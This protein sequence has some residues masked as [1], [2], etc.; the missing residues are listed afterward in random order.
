MGFL[1]FAS[2]DGPVSQNLSVFSPA[3]PQAAT[4]RDLFILVL[5]VTG[6]ILLLVEAIL[7][8]ALVRNR[9]RAAAG[10]AEPPQ[11]YGSKPI[12]IAWTA[13]PILIVFVLFLVTARAEWEVRPGPDDRPPT[14][15]QPL[16]V[17]VIGRQWWWE[18]VYDKYD[19]REMHVTT[20]NEL[21]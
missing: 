4:I 14:G 20:A 16:N 21:H 3:S 9:R 1:L 19:G 6:G 2:A 12:G 7:V 13:T 15:S 11:V 5:A 18:Y 17:T 8:Y 10:E